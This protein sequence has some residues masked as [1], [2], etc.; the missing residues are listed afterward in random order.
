MAIDEREIRSGTIEELSQTVTVA[1]A[2]EA[3][4]AVSSAPDVCFTWD[5]SRSRP[6]LA[7]LYEKAKTSMW[8]VSVD[9]DWD[10]DVD[11]ARIARD[12]TN[13]LMTTLSI[14]RAGT[15]LEGL[16]DEAPELAL[17]IRF[18]DG[19]RKDESIGRYIRDVARVLE[20]SR[21][22]LRQSW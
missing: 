6:A 3:V 13:P 2:E 1:E 18:S 16:S 4:H 11:P 9:I 15:V 7:K 14:D 19:A 5:Y 10:I 22:F 8:N 21:T 12:P 17:V 20:N